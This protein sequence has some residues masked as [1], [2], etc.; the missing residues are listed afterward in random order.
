MERHR[1][2]AQKHSLAAMTTSWLLP[3]VTLAV[4]SSSGA[5]LA[6]QL[7]KYSE[8]HALISVTTAVFL[9]T[10]S[11][12]L[13]FTILAIYIL[14]MIVH[15][16]P[17]GPQILSLCL[18]LGP[19]SQSGYAILHIGRS[20]RLLLPLDHGKSG[21]LRSHFTAD[22]IRAI[23]VSTAFL[24]WSIS[25]MCLIFAILGI[26]KIVRQARFPVR[27]PFWGVVFPHVSF[28]EA[29]GRFLK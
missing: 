24:L 19:I 6:I 27:L 14:R 4:A 10:V 17:P 22:I 25:C 8:L 15:G 29:L 7:Q 9:V 23:C 28:S 21:F 26:Q 11:L 18:P 13:T 20:F 12:L 16:L 5:A 2:T 3:I 1:S